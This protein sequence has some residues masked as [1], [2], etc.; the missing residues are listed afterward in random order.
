LRNR[1]ALKGTIKLA[2]GNHIHPSTQVDEETEKGQIGIGLRG[3]AGE[4]RNPVESLI[5]NGEMPDEGVIA[6]K[7]EWCSHFFSDLLDGNFLTVKLMTFI[8]KKMH[9]FL[10]ISVNK[11]FGN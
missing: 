4:V 1:S 10:Q 6:V 11:S 2:S 3:I 5:E 7:I 9:S 8:L